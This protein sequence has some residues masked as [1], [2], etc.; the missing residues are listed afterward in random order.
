MIMTY[1]RGDESGLTV[2]HKN[3]SIMAGCMNPARTLNIILKQVLR[4]LNTDGDEEMQ[5]LKIN[6]LK[7]YLT[8]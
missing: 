2:G 3:H 4:D 8:Q 6:Q 7:R 5:H 1:L